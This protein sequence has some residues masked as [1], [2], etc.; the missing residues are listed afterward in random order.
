MKEA[1]ILSDQD[2]ENLLAYLE[3]SFNIKI[4]SN[5]ERFGF[6]SFHL[7]RYEKERS[8]EWVFQIRWGSHQ[9]FSKKHLSLQE[10][11]LSQLC[12][13]IRANKYSIIKSAMEFCENQLNDIVLL[14]LGPELTRKL[15]LLNNYQLSIRK[16]RPGRSKETYQCLT[17]YGLCIS[18]YDNMGDY[19]EFLHPI[20]Y[21]VEKGLFD[22]SAEK[23]ASKFQ[24]Y[25]DQVAY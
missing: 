25:Q 16:I 1:N 11:Y 7:Y 22:F 10:D 8:T 15:P 19:Q 23:I 18:W 12:E 9:L 21:D 4:P 24:V 3:S 2:K 5:K 14:E 6:I 13:V 20:P 17:D